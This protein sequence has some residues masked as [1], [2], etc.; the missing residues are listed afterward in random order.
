MGIGCLTKACFVSRRRACRRRV[1][2]WTKRRQDLL[3]SETMEA[4]RKLS[5]LEDAAGLMH[6]PAMVCC[7]V[8]FLLFMSSSSQPYHSVHTTR[9]HSLNSSREQCTT[10]SHPSLNSA[11]APSHGRSR[12][13][14]SQ[15]S[16]YQ[17][18]VPCVPRTA[19]A[20]MGSRNTIGEV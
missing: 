8:V 17:C 11:A 13:I 12:P 9:P 20:S 3:D 19:L 18:Q 6:L 1:V 4:F 16:V 14:R 5:L 10:L 7:F 2:Q 15:L